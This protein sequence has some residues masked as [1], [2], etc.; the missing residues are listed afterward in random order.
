M[1]T[2]L[3]LAQQ[4]NDAPHSS[5]CRSHNL[6]YITV[7]PESMFPLICFVCLVYGFWE[8]SLSVSEA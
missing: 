5:Y 7:Y 2:Y 4:L 8:I 6:Y 3:C 1:S